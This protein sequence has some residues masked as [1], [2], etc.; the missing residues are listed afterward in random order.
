MNTWLRAPKKTIGDLLIPSVFLTVLMCT[1]IF[2]YARWDLKRFRESLR[3]QPEVSPVTVSQR[4]K[5]TDTHA[6]EVSPAE[7]VKP[8]LLIQQ[9]EEFKMETEA[10]LLETFDSVMN[11]PFHSEVEPSKEETTSVQ[12]EGL[13]EEE[14]TW[15]DQFQ[16]DIDGGSGFASLISILE[17][18]NVDRAGD[19]EDF[20]TVVQMLKRS[21]EGPMMADDLITMTE[22]WLRIQPDTPHVQSEINETRD[23][24]RNILSNLQDDKEKSLQSGEETRYMIHIY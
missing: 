15:Q 13:E 12:P 2:F 7:T 5:L 24:L 18:G 17:S 19:S 9:P 16:Q 10:P 14:V 21:T 4:E 1:G 20:A 23:S 8:K 6:E 22:A 11:E 3:E